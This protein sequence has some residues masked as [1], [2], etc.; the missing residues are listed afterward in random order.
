[1]R[2]TAEFV[3]S[4]Q[5]KHVGN[6]NTEQEEEA[7]ASQT[8]QEWQQQQEEQQQQMS[9]MIQNEGRGSGGGSPGGGAEGNG[10]NNG[11]M[12]QGANGPMQMN[13]PQMMYQMAPQMATGQG[14]PTTAAQQMQMMYQGNMWAQALGMAEMGLSEQWEQ[15][16]LVSATP[17]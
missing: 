8:W 1:M 2:N 12:Y 13:D 6:G 17:S 9:Q 3:P 7:L 15:R 16:E 5:R 11:I 14:E 10:A 4:S